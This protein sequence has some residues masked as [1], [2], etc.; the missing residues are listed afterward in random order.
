VRKAKQ[1]L[2]QEGHIQS[3]AGGGQHRQAERINGWALGL[4]AEA[5]WWCANS[6]QGQ[7]L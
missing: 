1:L 7:A 2:P 6:T 5:A 4:Q 3:P